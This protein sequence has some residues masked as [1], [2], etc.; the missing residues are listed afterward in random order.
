MEIRLITEEDYEQCMEL[1]AEFAEESLT[2]YGTYMDLE[3]LKRTFNMVAKTSFAAVVDNKVVGVLGGHI[4][5]DLC[6]TLPVYEEI[7]WYV[8]EKYRKYGIKLMR[9]VENYCR[10]N[11]INRITMSC[12]HNSKTEKLFRLYEKMGF[13][14]ME[15]RFMKELV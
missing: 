3:Q 1:V 4:R 15:T 7:I 6:S 14:P 5:A 11:N 12:M 2:E 10:E 8:S 13:T 9:F